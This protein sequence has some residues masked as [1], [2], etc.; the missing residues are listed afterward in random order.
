MV[1]SPGYVKDAKMRMMAD[2]VGLGSSR[3]QFGAHRQVR[4]SRQQETL[5]LSVTSNTHRGHTRRSSV[6]PQDCTALP[7]V[8]RETGP[9]TQAFDPPQAA[10][11]ES[12]VTGFQDGS[13]QLY[14][15]E[16]KSQTN[17]SRKVS[18]DQWDLTTWRWLLK[19]NQREWKERKW[20]SHRGELGLQR[21]TEEQM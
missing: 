1:L 17:K 18:V 20:R 4:L 9:G 12:L 11:P 8:S 16:L 14:Q 6:K 7:T 5:V 3:V 10:L 2:R 21:G 19:A 15:M 13:S